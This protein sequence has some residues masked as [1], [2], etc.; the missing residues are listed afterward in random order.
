M[1]ES[2]EIREGIERAFMEAVKDHEDHFYSVEVAGHK[3][4]VAANGE[5]GYTAMLPE[6]Y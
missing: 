4:F 1:S 6:E 5:M 2:S 3:F